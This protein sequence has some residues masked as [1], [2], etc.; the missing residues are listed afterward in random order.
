[1]AYIRYRVCQ[2]CHTKRRYSVISALID[3][4]T[5]RETWRCSKGHTFTKDVPTME[6]AIQ[7]MKAVYSPAR[8]AELAERPM[9]MLGRH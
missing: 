6:G 5:R 7:L 3:P 9:F 8:L 2:K 4:F 1:M